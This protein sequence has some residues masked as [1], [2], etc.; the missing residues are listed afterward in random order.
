MAERVLEAQL[1]DILNADGL[2]KNWPECGD[3]LTNLIKALP[4]RDLA[5]PLLACDAAGG[6]PETALP[7]ALAW[8]ALHSG[9][10]LLD[11]V[12]DRDALEGFQSYEQIAALSSGPIFSA[13]NFLARIGDPVIITR[14]AQTLFQGFFQCAH[15]QYLDLM[16]NRSELPGS[17]AMKTYWRMTLLKSGSV[18]QTGLASGAAVATSSPELLQAL[19]QYGQAFGVIKQIMDDCTDFLKENGDFEMT[20]PVLLYQNATQN[21]LPKITDRK[22]LFK[23]LDQAHI[24][25]K[26][27]TVITEW[28]RRALE[29][30]TSLPPS[31][32]KE[33]LK[34]YVHD[35]V[36]PPEFFLLVNTN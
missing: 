5:F 30:L 25:E 1:L 3:E 19:G 13:Q 11:K 31:N 24:P 35:L 34:Q 18:Y 9:V 6:K 28:Q 32:A 27:V 10:V 26:L 8:I 14:T 2:I 7:V 33:R 23:V 12:L 4:E 16:Q 36:Y 17:Q 15:G 20:L 29:S 21:P 22:A